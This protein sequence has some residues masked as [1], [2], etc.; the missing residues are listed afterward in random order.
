MYSLDKLKATVFQ[1]YA[2]LKGA[3]MVL[4]QAML[5]LQTLY[6]GNAT[7]ENPILHQANYKASSKY[8]S[9]ELQS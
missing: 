3:Q 1:A 4:C 2:T 9:V 8:V 6:Q 5:A 7:K